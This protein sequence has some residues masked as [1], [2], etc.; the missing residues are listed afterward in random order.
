M[1]LPVRMKDLYDK[2]DPKFTKSNTDKLDASRVIPK[3][4]QLD[5]NLAKLL[6]LKLDAITTKFLIEQSNP[7]SQ[8]P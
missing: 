8:V 7:V 1:E 6:T 4:E 3:T 5:P 2:P